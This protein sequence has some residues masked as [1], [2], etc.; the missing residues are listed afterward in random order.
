MP[1]FEPF[2]PG[3][4]AASQDSDEEEDEDEEDPEDE[5]DE[6]EADLAAGR[7]APAP[8]GGPDALA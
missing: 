2:F 4:V 6:Q 7:C 3:G 1:G 5:D 8:G